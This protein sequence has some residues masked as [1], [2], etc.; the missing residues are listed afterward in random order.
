MQADAVID[1]TDHFN[2]ESSDI[3][4]R[5]DSLISANR[6]TISVADL[7]MEGDAALDVSSMGPL[8]I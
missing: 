6:I 3:H 1:H 5:F 7:H 4:M 2:L 8:T